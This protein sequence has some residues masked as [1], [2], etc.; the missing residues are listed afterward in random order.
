MMLLNE[1]LLIDITELSLPGERS[2]PPASVSAI[3]SLPTVAISADQAR[4]GKKC[5]VCLLEYDIREQ[6]KQ[7]PCQH[8]FHSGCI[9]PWLKKTNSC[10][11]CRYELPT[12]DPDYEE[13]RRDKVKAKEKE[14]RIGSLHD[15]MYS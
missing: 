2:A 15:S 14:A 13:Y 1:G 5:P 7:L 10:P 11:V 9:L 12:D 8:Q 6:T 3:Q 4:D